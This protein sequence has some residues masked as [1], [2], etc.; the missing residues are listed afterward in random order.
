MI[1]LLITLCICLTAAGVCILF[2]YRGLPTITIMHKAETTII[3]ED[4]YVGETQ[5]CDDTEASTED[6][7]D[8]KDRAMAD[9]AAVINSIMEGTGDF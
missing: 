1:S 9:V 7:Y 6:E 5:G 3:G 4:V 2:S 8:T